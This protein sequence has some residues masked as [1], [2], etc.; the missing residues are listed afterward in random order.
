MQ[1]LDIATLD[2]LEDLLIH[3]DLQHLLLIGAYRDNEVTSDHPLT[4]RLD[5]LRGAGTSVQEIVLSPLALE[6]VG[7]FVAD[8]LYCD[9][10]GAAPLAELMLEKTAGNPYFVIQ[11]LTELVEQGLVTFDYGAARWLWDLVSI[12]VKGY[13]DNVVDLMVGKLE[14]PADSHPKVLAAA[15]L[16]RR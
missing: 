1:W 12:H 9:C 4:R 2:L 5:R 6:H 8:S 3:P 16:S 11:F 13:T 7:Q 15:R 14:S 10:E